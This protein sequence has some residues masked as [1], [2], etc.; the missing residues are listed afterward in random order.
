MDETYD[1]FEELEVLGLH[2]TRYLKIPK[3]A[4]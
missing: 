1:T 2:K 4:N 3:R